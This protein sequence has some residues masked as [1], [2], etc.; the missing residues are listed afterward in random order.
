MAPSPLVTTAWLEEHLAD[1]NLRI[2]EVCSRDDDKAYR[3]GHIPGAAWVYWK[4][5]CWHETDRQFI[6]PEAMARLFGGMGIGPDTTVVLTGDPVQF[7]TYAFW[8]FTM[9]GHRD[10][11]L[12]DGARRKWL[13]EGRPLTREV[14]RYSPVAYPAPAGN[15]STR[16]GRDNVRDNLKK[17]GRLLLDA[18]S[19]E[20]YEG[21]RVADYSFAF[22]HGAERAGRIPGAAHL[23]FKRAELEPK[24]ATKTYERF[25]AR[26]DVDAA[27]A[28][29]FEDL[30]RNLEAPH[31]LGM[32][33][34]LVVPEGQREVFREDWEL[35]GR[36]EP[37]VD[38]LTD[39]LD[40]FLE[41]ILTPPHTA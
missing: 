6:S 20:E 25:L 19:P 18:R 2:I 10:L 17:P 8:A 26:H 39:D 13:A 9:A 12:L 4:S 15:S 37:H 14:A 38:Y 31:A 7:G 33:T 32:I 3:E 28:A 27:K 1:P 21:K 29:M 22:D 16:V 24:P 11:R 35:E 5:A 23:Y 41:R 34:V 30:A 40:G 36:D